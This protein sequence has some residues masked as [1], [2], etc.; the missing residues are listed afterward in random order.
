MLG[1]RVEGI[2][3]DP[4]YRTDKAMLNKL[5]MDLTAKVDEAE[6][7]EMLVKAVLATGQE[8]KAKKLAQDPEVDVPWPP[9]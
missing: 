1:G 9:K 8:I 7:W 6:L 2:Q 3:H 5:I 4:M